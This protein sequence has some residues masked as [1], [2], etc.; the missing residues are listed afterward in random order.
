MVKALSKPTKPS[1]KLKPKPGT[2]PL[3][4]PLDRPLELLEGQS[5]ANIT[6]EQ[7]SDHLKYLDCCKTIIQK[8]LE[9]KVQQL[10][11]STM[12]EESRR[13][14]LLMSLRFQYSFLT[15]K[16]DSQFF[17]TQHYI[18]M[19]NLHF[20]KGK[21]LMVEVNGLVLTPSLL[22]PRN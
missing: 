9:N 1:R 13:L 7:K 8:Y 2:I 6:P 10:G 20:S 17:P 21:N 11:D 4:M 19:L 3:R 16:W 12:L 14:A 15:G 5:L 18:I 22:D